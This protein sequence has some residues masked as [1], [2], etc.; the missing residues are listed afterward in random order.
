MNIGDKIK[1][2]NEYNELSV[3]VIMDV[4]SSMPSYDDMKLENGIP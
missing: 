2:M 3:C 1:Y 4:S